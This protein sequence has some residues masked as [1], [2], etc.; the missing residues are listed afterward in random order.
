MRQWRQIYKVKTSPQ[1]TGTI[2]ADVQ[3][4]HIHSEQTIDLVVYN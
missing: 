1:A 2:E 3:S 4:V